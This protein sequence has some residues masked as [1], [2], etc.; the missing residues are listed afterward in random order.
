[1]FSVSANLLNLFILLFSEI[2]SHSYI[3]VFKLLTSFYNI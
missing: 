1:M 3:S 2:F